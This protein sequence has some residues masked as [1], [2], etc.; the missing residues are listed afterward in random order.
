[1]LDVLRYFEPSPTSPQQCREV[2]R[3]FATLA[4]LLAKSAHPEM[5]KALS[6][7]LESRDA[8]MRALLYAQ[9]FIG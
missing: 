4:T 2:E 8:A 3:Q 1:M 6:K 9:I 5:A 7:L